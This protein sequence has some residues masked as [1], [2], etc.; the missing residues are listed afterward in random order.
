MKETLSYPTVQGSITEFS[1]VLYVIL[2]IDGDTEEIVPGSLL[3]SREPSGP[4]VDGIILCTA[5]LFRVFDKCYRFLVIN[6]GGL[7]EL[8][9]SG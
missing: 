6:F 3:V 4:T 8:C 2:V 9:K 5:Q 7:Y 1:S